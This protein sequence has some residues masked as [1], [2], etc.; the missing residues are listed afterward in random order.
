MGWHGPKSSSLNAYFGNGESRS[1][2]KNYGVLVSAHTSLSDHR[3]SLPPS[4]VRLVGVKKRPE[5]Y[6]DVFA[7]T[8]QVILE[9]RRVTGERELGIESFSRGLT[10]RSDSEKTMIQSGAKIVNNVPGQF[11]KTLGELLDQ[12]HFCREML[13][14]MRVRLTKDRV[15]VLLL[16]E[17]VNPAI[18]VGK[19]FLCP[20]DLPARTFKG[21]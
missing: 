9:V 17:L 18:E 4:L 12:S 16:K 19:V 3:A 1:N 14:I 10:N 13:G 21:V 15:Q 7:S 20:R 6:R 8:P 11:R 5:F 2:R